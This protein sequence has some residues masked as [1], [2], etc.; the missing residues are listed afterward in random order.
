MNKKIH[1]TVITLQNIRNYG[2]ALQALATQHVMKTLGLECDFIDYWRKG[3][4][5]LSRVKEWTNGK[6]I[7]LRILKGLI[8]LP[9]FIK[10]NRIFDRFNRHY[11]NL[12]PGHFTNEEEI[13]KGLKIISDIYCT[14]SDQTWNSGWNG[15]ILPEFFLNFVPD[16]VKRISYA[17]SFGK[18]TLDEDEID[19]TRKYLKKYHAISVRE[20]SAVDIIEK[21]LGLQSVT[22]VL[23]PTLQVDSSF[24]LSLLNENQIKRK[25]KGKYVLI[26]QLN[27]N[28]KFDEYAKLFARKKGWKLYRFCTR[29][30]QFFKCGKSMLVPEITEFISLIANAGCVI[31]DSFHATAFSCNFNTPMICIFPASY[32]SRLDSLLR[33]VGLEHRHL[34]DY[35]DF[36]FVDNT[37]VDFANVNKVLERERIVG[38]NFLKNAFNF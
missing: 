2:S 37:S 35:D 29:Y 12:I 22:H 16:N 27:T 11:L 9:T 21:Q 18:A 28:H 14:G 30:D 23:D 5:T 8:L 33:L 1:I 19:I 38:L 26:Y 10:Q 32:S 15:G 3:Y 25:D 7:F 24:W 34:A 13:K 36:S 6:N 31:T 20:K 4:N 17:A